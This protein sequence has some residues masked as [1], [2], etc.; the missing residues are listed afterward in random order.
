V[1]LHFTI[2]GKPSAWQRA[3]HFVDKRSGR[4]VAANPKGMAEAQNLIAWACK[5]VQRGAPPLTGPLRLEVLCVYGVPPSWPN[6]KRA[7]ALAGAVWKT[8]APDHDNLTKQVGD[9]LNGVAYVDDAQIVRSSV[10]KRYGQ[11]E[12]TEVRLSRVDGLA[13][14]ATQQAFQEWL[15]INGSQAQMKAAGRW[16]AARR[17]QPSLPLPLANARNTLPKTGGR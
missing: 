5:A 7:A 1:A 15:A 2:P 17:S 8:S 4:M 11:P 3:A 13:D 12:R 6:W 9:A 16:L 14:D 10:A